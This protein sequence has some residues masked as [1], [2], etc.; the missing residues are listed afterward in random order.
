[1]TSKTAIE[2]VVFGGLVPAL[3]ALMVFVAISWLWPAE[4]ARRYSV[5]VAFAAAVLVGFVALPATKTL[6]PLKSWDWIAYLGLLAA[7]VTGLLRAE[8]VLRGERWLA[9]YLF[10]MLAGW[11]TV[12]HWPELWPAW[13][14]QVALFALAIVVVSVLLEFLPAHLTGRPLP[15]WLM[16]AAVAV[17][18]LLT[19]EVSVTSGQLAAVPAG[20]LAG[21]A[22]AA[23][24]KRNAASWRG[25]ALP[26]ATVVGG[27]AYVGAIYPTTPVWLLVAVPLA[28]LALWLSAIGP[29]AQV[30][31]WKAGAIQ[32]V[33]VIVPLALVAAVLLAR[34]GGGEEW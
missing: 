32:A 13:P 9:V 2:F 27:Y 6:L 29:F 24:L 34:G 12:P 31:G 20:A 33:C 11:L 10:A 30:R 8:G 17:S 26:Y 1:L 15:G 3:A 5:G 7:F 22:M 14:V 25:L 16:L 21:C 18:V 28:P 4:A 23:L 19:A